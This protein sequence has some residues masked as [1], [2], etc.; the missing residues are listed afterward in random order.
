M[1]E[2][3]PSIAAAKILPVYS[4]EP[5]PFVERRRE[6]R[7]P[8]DA[9]PARLQDETSISMPAHVLDV[10]ISGIRVRVDCVLPVGSEATVYFGST[11][12]VGQV[13]FCR[14]NRDDSF[15]AG[16]QISDVL[17]TV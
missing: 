2:S 13:R 7:I 15:E 3:K 12:A 17:N 5:H 8:S 10:S 4:P 6:Q 14:R 16:L 1:P 11:I 9:V